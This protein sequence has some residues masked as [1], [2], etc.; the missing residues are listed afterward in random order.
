MVSG[1]KGTTKGLTRFKKSL[2]M[3]SA[4]AQFALGQKFYG[5]EGVK[6]DREAAR[7]LRR[8]RILK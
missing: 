6:K 8:A 1:L 7:V 2:G 3:G 4:D 5:G